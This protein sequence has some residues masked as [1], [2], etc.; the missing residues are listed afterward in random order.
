MLLS[1]NDRAT[2]H[3]FRPAA[4]PQTHKGDISYLYYYHYYYYDLNNLMRMLLFDAVEADVDNIAVLAAAVQKIVGY[5]NMD[6][7]DVH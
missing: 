6:G 1:W 5:E 4:I 2:N 3:V 7:I